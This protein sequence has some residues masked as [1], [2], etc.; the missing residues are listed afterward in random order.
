M[1]LYA[2]VARGKS[3]LAEHT[4]MVGNFPTVTRVLLAKINTEQDGKMSY[5]YDKH[6]FHYLCDRGIIFLCMC[7]NEVTKKRIAFQFLDEIRGT[8]RAAYSELENSAVAFAMQSEFSPILEKQMT[9]FSDNKASDNIEKLRVQIDGVKEIMCE[10]IDNLLERGEKI[11]L[12][13]DKTD[14]LSQTA[15]KFE[16]SSRALK[17]SVYCNRIRMYLIAFVVIAVIIFIIA[18]SACGMKLDKCKS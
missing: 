7:E 1:I 9:Y 12:L 15:F 2:L 5:L 6:I 4:K 11:E 16:K 17:R 18:F 10:N 3:V 14:K 8:W 13:V